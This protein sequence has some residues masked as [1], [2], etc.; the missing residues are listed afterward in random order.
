MVNT[1]AKIISHLYRYPVPHEIYNATIT[2]KTFTP[3]I[4]KSKTIQIVKMI[5]ADKKKVC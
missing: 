3:S 4:Q 2:F 5:G 1:P